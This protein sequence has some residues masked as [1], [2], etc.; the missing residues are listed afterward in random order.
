MRT[1]SLSR[2]TYASADRSVRT[3]CHGAEQLSGQGGGQQA[4]VPT[5][6]SVDSVYSLAPKPTSAR[7]VYKRELGVY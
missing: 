4:E 5:S 6:L 3:V 7:A 2:L 1:P